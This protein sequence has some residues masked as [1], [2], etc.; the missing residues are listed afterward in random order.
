VIARSIEHPSPN[1][2]KTWLLPRDFKDVESLTGG[3]ISS[4]EDVPDW[5]DAGFAYRRPIDSIHAHW[6]FTNYA[7]MALDERYQHHLRVVIWKDFLTFSD[8]G[9]LPTYKV[10]YPY[11][12]GGLPNTYLD[13]PDIYSARFINQQGFR[14]QDQERAKVEADVWRRLEMWLS[15]AH[16]PN[17]RLGAQFVWVSPHGSRNEGYIGTDKTHPHLI[18]FY[19]K[20]QKGVVFT[21]FKSWSSVAE[22]SNLQYSLGLPFPDWTNNQLSSRNQVIERSGVIDKTLSEEEIEHL[23]YNSPH[24]PENAWFVKRSDL[25]VVNLK[26]FNAVREAAFEQYVLWV[27]SFLEAIKD[28]APRIPQYLSSPEFESLL[29]DHDTLFS[30]LGQTLLGWIKNNDQRIIRNNNYN[31]ELVKSIKE[32]ISPRSLLYNHSTQTPEA[33]SNFLRTAF[34]LFIKKN[35]GSKITTKEMRAFNAASSVY[36][37]ESVMDLIGFGQCVSFS[38]ISRSL[39]KISNPSGFTTIQGVKIPRRT[40]VKEGWLERRGHCA[41]TACKNPRSLE[42][43]RVFLGPC[44][45]CSLCDKRFESTIPTKQT[46]A[47]KKRT[48]ID[49]HPPTPFFINES[50]SLSQLIAGNV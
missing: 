43:K 25:P 46:T 20:T 9:M 7:K 32:D 2:E 33:V 6:N 50:V 47:L 37:L 27:T 39:G 45:Y 24:E 18:S 38:Y 31:S 34:N 44:D 48:P 13:V 41:N 23:I 4:I 16:T 28:Q 11:G 22:L 26:D 21:Q 12:I 29:N 36:M 8:E 35:H 40:A 17:I 3:L 15:A 5:I 19:T 10:S 1:E 42:G 49:Q 14:S 30:V